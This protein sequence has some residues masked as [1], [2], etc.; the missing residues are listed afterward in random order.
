[1]YVDDLLLFASNKSWLTNILHQLSARLKMTNLG[2]IS[3]YL[4]IEVDVETWKIS[5]RQTTYLRKILE[6]FQMID[7]KPSSIPIKPGVA[8]SLLSSDYQA[9]RGIMK[10]YQS[11]IGSIIWPTVH[12]RTDISHIVWVLSRYCANPSPIYCNLVIEIF[13]YL[14]ETLELEITFKSNV[15]DEL[16]GYTDSD[17]AGFKDGRRSKS[18]YIFFLS[19]GP[20]SHQSKQQTSFA[21][22]L[23]E[24]E[25]M[26]TKEAGKEA[27]WIGQFLA[28]LGYRLLSQPVSLRANN[29]RALL[30]TGNPEFHPHTKYIKVRYQW[31]QEK[32]QSKGIAINLV[33][34]KT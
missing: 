8:N 7:R 34:T 21:L 30:L 12:T 24:A 25:Y 9:D 6:R 5:L 13:W 16:V 10:W 29:R 14:T 33:S 1:M 26:A 11:A 4:G 18:E 22:S 28:A 17:W 27:L 19:I 23:T 32:F 3:H 15:T 20:V 2:E 31:I